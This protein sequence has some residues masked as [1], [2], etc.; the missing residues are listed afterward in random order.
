MAAEIKLKNLGEIGTIRGLQIWRVKEFDLEEVPK[1]QYGSFY[2]GD[3]YVLL[4][5]CRLLP[6][7]SRKK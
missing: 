4:N 2:S 1:N 7:L 6:I 5:V 3:C